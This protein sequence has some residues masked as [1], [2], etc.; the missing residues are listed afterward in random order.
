MNSPLI[1]TEEY[2]ADSMLSIVRHT[3]QIQFNGHVYTIVDKLGRDI[4]E[5]SHIA[6]KE[7]REKAIEPGEPCDLVRDDII[8]AYRI[9]GR[10]RIIALCKEGVGA[11]AI[12]AAAGIKPKAPK[13]TK[14]NKNPKKSS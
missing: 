8:P 4:F 7:G 1:M 14:K 13:S 2:W 11:E 12:K 10:D 3:G 5:C 9:L 6:H